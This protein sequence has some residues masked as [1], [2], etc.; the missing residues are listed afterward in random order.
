MKK[1]WV[2]LIAMTIIAAM[3]SLSACEKSEPASIEGDDG[4]AAITEE[5]NNEKKNVS[6]GIVNGNCRKFYD[7][8]LSGFGS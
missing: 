8:M 4:S 6:P 3:F 1:Y 5:T 7:R 2:A